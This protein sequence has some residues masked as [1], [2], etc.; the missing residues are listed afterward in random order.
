MRQTIA[1]NKQMLAGTEEMNTFKGDYLIMREVLEKSAPNTARKRFQRQA[2]EE[3]LESEQSYQVWGF[4]HTGVQQTLNTRSEREITCGAG[5][6]ED[7]NC[8]N[9][10]ACAE[11]VPIRKLLEYQN[12]FASSVRQTRRNHNHVHVEDVEDE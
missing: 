10:N 4:Q 11:V 6:W 2:M 1:L 9:Q 8:Y 5:P 7:F 12:D 3:R